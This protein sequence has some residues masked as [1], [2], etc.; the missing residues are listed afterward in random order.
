MIDGPDIADALGLD[1]GL[2][3]NDF[4][5]QAL[6]LPAL[7]PEWAQDIGSVAAPEGGLRLVL[8]PGTGLGA[9]ALAEVRGQLLPLATEIG[10]TDFGPVGAEEE[11][12]W[13]HLERAH[14]RVTAECVISGPGLV[15]LH[16]AGLASRG[17]SA[18]DIDGVAIVDR[19]L[20]GG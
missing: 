3:L 13:G 10:H 7:L 4:E 11:Q 9:A 6:S 12:I 8:G 5:A 16:K 14:G 2:L 17:T 20:A 1:Q 15:R 19:A 18:P